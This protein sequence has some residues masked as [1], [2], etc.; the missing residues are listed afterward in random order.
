M[1]NFIDKEVNG[2]KFIKLIGKGAFGNVKWH[3][4][5]GLLREKSEH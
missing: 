3:N 5:V 2:Y 1:N 4:K